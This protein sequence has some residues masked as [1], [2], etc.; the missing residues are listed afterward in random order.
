MRVPLDVAALA[1]AVAIGVAATDAGAD[2]WRRRGPWTD[3]FVEVPLGD[4]STDV[5]FPRGGAHPRVPG[6]VAVNRAP[7]VCAPHARDFRD[8]SAFV[9]HL[10]TRHGLGDDD[11]PR[12]LLVD[13]GQVRY[14]GD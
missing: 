14:L 13:G 7:Y 11:I 6:V 5:V 10:R 1:A 8:R 4:H 12:A 9:A 3:L 2:P